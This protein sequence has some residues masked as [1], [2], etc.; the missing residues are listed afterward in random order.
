MTFIRVKGPYPSSILKVDSMLWCVCSVIDHSWCQIVVRTKEWHLK[1]SQMC[2]RCD[3][4]SIGLN[5][6]K[7]TRFGL[8][9]CKKQSKCV[10]NSPCFIIFLW[11]YSFIIDWSFNRAEYHRKYKSLDISGWVWALARSINR[12][13]WTSSVI[14][15]VKNEIVGCLVKSRRLYLPFYLMK[16]NTYFLPGWRN[17]KWHQY[18]HALTGWRGSG[19]CWW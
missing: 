16:R 2:H 13:W 1:G 9:W 18:R 3:R 5:D 14:Y 4:K 17:R 19:R 12:C 10:Y 8:W 6:K 11:I 7:K 15:L